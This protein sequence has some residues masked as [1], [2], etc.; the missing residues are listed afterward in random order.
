MDVKADVI[1]AGGALAGDEA[2]ITPQ[3]GRP[4]LPPAIT[5]SGS[6]IGREGA[7]APSGGGVSTAGSVG[8]VGVSGMDS[9][10]GS[11][12]GMGVAVGPDDATAE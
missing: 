12:E 2:E 4:I 1:P 10:G 3:G 8:G 6:S 9:A 5:F 7:V 11:G